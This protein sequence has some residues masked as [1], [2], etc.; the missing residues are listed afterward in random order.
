MCAA[1]A[2]SK[3]HKRKSICCF[4][5]FF[6][7]IFHLF[8]YVS[9]PSFLSLRFDENKTNIFRWRFIFTRAVPEVKEEKKHIYIYVCMYLPSQPTLKISQAPQLRAEHI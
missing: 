4:F 1:R 2:F 3:V 5:F 6:S 9:H 7:K 8:I